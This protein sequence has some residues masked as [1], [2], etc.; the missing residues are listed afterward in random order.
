MLVKLQQ[1]VLISIILLVFYVVGNLSRAS[2][3]HLH[4]Y[5]DDLLTNEL[6]RRTKE[7]KK[8]YACSIEFPSKR[9][10]KKKNHTKRIFCFGKGLSDL[11]NFD[12]IHNYGGCIESGETYWLDKTVS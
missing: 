1:R 11:F 10:K 2:T 12:R 9:K 5:R 7:I 3:Q 6:S 8:M 4:Q